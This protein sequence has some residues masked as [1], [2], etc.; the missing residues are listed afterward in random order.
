MIILF[1]P[2]YFCRYFASSSK[3]CD[4]RIW[5]SVLCNTILT[6]SGHTKSVTVIKWGG[7]G[8]IYSA[9]QDRTVKVWR[10]KDGILCRT[11]EG[12]AHWVNYFIISVNILSMLIFEIK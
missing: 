1:L 6:I 7:S 8:L 5:D 4:I 3:D 2:G 10:A 11:L 9:S 12:H